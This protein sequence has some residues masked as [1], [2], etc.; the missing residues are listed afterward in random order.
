MTVLSPNDLRDWLACL[1]PDEGKS[2]IAVLKVSV[3]ESGTHGGAPALVVTAC[4][5]T[6]KG[7]T[8]I[9]RKWRP[10]AANYPKGYHATQARD[11][12][13]LFLASLLQP[14]LEA[15]MAV[16][17]PY[18]VFKA[19]VPHEHRSRFG[20]EYATAIRACVHVLAHWCDNYWYDWTTWVLETGHKGEN[21]AR[22]FLDSIL[23]LPASH[24]HS[25]AWVGKNDLVTHAPDVVSYAIVSTMESARPAS[26]RLLAE[27]RKST[28]VRAFDRPT[29]EEAVAKGYDTIK[30]QRR[31]ALQA[32][33][34]RKNASKEALSADDA[35]PG[36]SWE[37]PT[38]EHE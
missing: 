36:V 9:L 18:E 16:V 13:N 29:L 26:T 15:S 19:V 32:R 25:Q 31:T 12:D 24:V 6:P 38:S 21:S 30:Q 5:G 34:Q 8:R 3:D 2:A 27:V 4:V 14:H 33:K 35:L 23:G 1:Q 10:R 11:E 20:A 22:R 7:W 28:M 17:I 37:A